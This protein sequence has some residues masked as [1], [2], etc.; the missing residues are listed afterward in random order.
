MSPAPGS[1]IGHLRIE[2]PLGEGGMSEV[3]PGST[4]GSRGR[5]R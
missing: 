4:S 1:R 5:S 3:Y 2:A